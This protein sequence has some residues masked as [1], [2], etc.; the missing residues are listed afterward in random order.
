MTLMM[1]LV[2]ILAACGSTNDEKSEKGVEDNMEKAEKV[3]ESEI[4]EVEEDGAISLQLL[5]IDEEAGATLDT[6]PLYIELN[7]MI[8]E[9][10]ELGIPDDFSIEVIDI[11]DSGTEDAALMF[12]A[13]N[14]TP[15]AL[16]NISFDYTLGHENGEFVWQDVEVELTEEDAGV[17]QP[18]H[19]MPFSLGITAEQEALIDLINADNKV[20]EMKNADVEFVE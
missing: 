20:M 7:E 3:E 2:L 18:N 19:A 5:K 12:L 6:H 9:A 15:V 4:E 8:Q 14:R 17:I 16:K 13:I 10:P 11:V 1:A